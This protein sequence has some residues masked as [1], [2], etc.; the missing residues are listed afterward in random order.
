MVLPSRLTDRR[1]NGIAADGGF[2]LIE[3]M[4]VVLII[5]ILMALA[6]PVFAGAKRRS[7]DRATHHDLRSGLLAAKTYHADRQTYLSTG[8]NMDPAALNQMMGGSL[9]F[10]NTIGNASTTVMGYTGSANGVVFVR[11]SRSGAWFCVA[12]VVSGA[13]AGTY[14]DTGAGLTDVDTVA[15]C[16]QASW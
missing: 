13:P 12:D 1:R 6:I 5:S 4:V 11:E 16:N 8:G 3:L 14:Y 10:D 7:F 15:E 2:T 9:A